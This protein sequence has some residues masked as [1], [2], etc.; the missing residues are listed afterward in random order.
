MVGV[1]PAHDRSAEAETNVRGQPAG[2]RVVL[3]AEGPRGD[4][5]STGCNDDAI[6]GGGG[7]LR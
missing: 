6:T 2:Y 3:V 4:P 1:K 5:T 7:K